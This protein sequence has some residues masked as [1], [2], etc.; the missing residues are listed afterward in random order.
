MVVQNVS[1]G[2]VGGV[3]ENIPVIFNQNELFMDMTE[4][5][6]KLSSSIKKPVPDVTMK[7]QRQVPIISPFHK[8]KYMIKAY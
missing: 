4:G 5:T 1:T 2:N 7:P 3:G 8:T 6:F